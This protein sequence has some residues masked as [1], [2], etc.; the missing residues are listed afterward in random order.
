[1]FVK[2]FKVSTDEGMDKES[3]LVEFSAIKL[4]QMCLHDWRTI[5]KTS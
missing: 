2:V 5:S 3:K 4:F 1:M